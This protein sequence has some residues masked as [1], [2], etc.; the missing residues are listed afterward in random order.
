[1]A[2][3]EG[4]EKLFISSG[5]NKLDTMLGGGFVPGQLC[6]I[7]YKMGDGGTKLMHWLAMSLYN[8]G[9]RVLSLSF[10]QSVSEVI[11]NYTS[12]ISNT[13]LNKIKNSDDVLKVFSNMKEFNKSTYGKFSVDNIFFSDNY[14]ESI[15]TYI[16]DNNPTV[17]MLGINPFGT[18]KDNHY[19][20]EAYK[21]LA[22]KY[23]IPIIT[24]CQG[25]RNVMGPLI[26]DSL[27]RNYL[28][29]SDNIIGVTKELSGDIIGVDILKSKY[30]SET[31]GELFININKLKNI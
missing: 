31:T 28:N 20:V 8:S 19:M 6:S 7:A 4:V 16:Q 21:N 15:E 30:A 13:P 12:I 1:M 18:Y 24:G 17:L 23:N 29:M 22:F 14:L 10:E 2:K 25:Y 11:M 26:P 9:E 5:N 27:D 3:M